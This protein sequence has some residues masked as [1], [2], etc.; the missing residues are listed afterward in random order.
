M[1][2]MSTF[3]EGMEGEQQ[4]E[5]ILASMPNVQYV[6]N[7]YATYN[8]KITQID[9]IAI[10]AF[11]IVCIEVKNIRGRIDGNEER[12]NWIAHRN[13]RR[14]KFF[15]PIYQ[16]A[17]HI[18][19]LS[20]NIGYNNPRPIRNLVV[21]NNEAELPPLPQL[22]HMDSLTFDSTT[23]F[24]RDEIEYWKGKILEIK[25]QNEHLCVR[26]SRETSKHFNP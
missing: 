15:N 7:V 23:V 17:K 4:V 24:D 3:F 10:G 13:G 12:V 16:N 22:V 11:G 14:L 5:S 21:F 6:S 8:D 19:L 18:Y 9:I 1:R 2:N 25:R 26:H 20:K